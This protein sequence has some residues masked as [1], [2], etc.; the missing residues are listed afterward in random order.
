M[1]LPRTPH[2]QLSWCPM[3][4]QAHVFGVDLAPTVSYNGVI[5]S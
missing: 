5:Q 1:T 2:A 3:C 4:I